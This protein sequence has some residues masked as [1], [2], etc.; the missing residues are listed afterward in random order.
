MKISNEFIDSSIEQIKRIIEERQKESPYDTQRLE[1]N[2][3]LILCLTILVNVISYYIPQGIDKLIRI[4]RKSLVEKRKGE[5]E[6]MD[7]ETCEHSI[8]DTLQLKEVLVSILKAKDINDE[9][10]VDRIL[11]LI[12][13]KLKEES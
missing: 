7:I 13:G 8:N 5:I 1:S 2:D 9:E 10:V 6:G 12:E 11:E 4:P 3:V